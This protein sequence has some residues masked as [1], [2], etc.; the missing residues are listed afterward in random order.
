MADGTS[1]ITLCLRVQSDVFT[2]GTGDG[3]LCGAVTRHCVPIVYPAATK[4]ARH[5][6][7]VDVIAVQNKHAKRVLVSQGVSMD[8]VEVWGSARHC[9]EWTR[10]Y[11]SVL[12]LFRF[13]GKRKVVFMLPWLGER[14]WGMPTDIPGTVELIKRIAALPG[15][16]LALKPRTREWNRTDFGVEFDEW[17][18]MQEN[19]RWCRDVSSPA[20]IR[21]AD[22]VIIVDSS[23]GFEAIAQGKQL[24]EAVYLTSFPAFYSTYG[25]GIYAGCLNQCLSTLFCT[26][27]TA[28]IN[29]EPV[30]R[31][32][33][34]PNGPD[35]LGVFAEKIAGAQ[36]KPG[37]GHAR[38]A[39]RF[40]WHWLRLY[41][42]FVLRVLTD[43]PDRVLK[44]IWRRLRK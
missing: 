34:W 43:R 31:D 13:D 25:L 10:E 3:A 24:I 1:N 44:R 29:M 35:V 4:T 7:E 11:L 33:L 42:P 17:V 16:V 32:W 14:G 12:P 6:D 8:R 27:H 9:E 19:V 30:K 21:W 37:A 38:M 26:P 23:I 5:L 39:L 15:V 36:H 22:S 20:L 2:H 41:V 28:R 40:A 18:N